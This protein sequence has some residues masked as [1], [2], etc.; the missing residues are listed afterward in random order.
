MRGAG[1]KDEGARM[2]GAGTKD[3]GSR[4]EGSR[5][6][7]RGSKDEGSRDGGRRSKDEGSRAE[8]KQSAARATLSWVS[9]VFN[10]LKFVLHIS[11]YHSSH[12]A[13]ETS[14]LKSCLNGRRD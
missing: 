1:T 2:R 8:G 9:S 13:G 12:Y 5:D 14:A 6:E 11:E 7:G 3:E 10:F 4:D